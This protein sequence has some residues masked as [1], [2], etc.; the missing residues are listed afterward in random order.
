MSR[1][2]NIIFSLTQKSKNTIQLNNQLKNLQSAQG[3][4]LF[5]LKGLKDSVREIINNGDNKSDH[6]RNW[7]VCICSTPDLSSFKDS[8]ETFKIQ[9]KML[10]Y[11]IGIIFIALGIKNEEKQKRLNKYMSISDSLMFLKDP[12]LKE[13]RSVMSNINNVTIMHENLIYEKF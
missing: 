7:I 5:L 2:V 13:L 1:K 9:N 6:N 4:R 10:N 12:S 8:I 11:K 3:N